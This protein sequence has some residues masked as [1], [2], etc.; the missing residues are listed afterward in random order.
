[1]I[2]WC[3]ACIFCKFYLEVSFKATVRRQGSNNCTSFHRLVH[4]A[5]PSPW[6]SNPIFLYLANSSAVVKM[7]TKIWVAKSYTPWLH[8]STT[9][10]SV[11]KTISK[12]CSSLALL[13]I[14]FL[15]QTGT[16]WFYLKIDQWCPAGN[17]LQVPITRKTWA[18]LLPQGNLLGMCNL[19]VIY[20]LFCC[21]FSFCIV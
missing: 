9:E 14:Q 16:R 8:S 12:I 13:V 5:A 11:L 10:A 4:P 15:D 17:Y 3:C 6:P 7:L 19:W 1:M 2:Q 21:C 20:N 18:F